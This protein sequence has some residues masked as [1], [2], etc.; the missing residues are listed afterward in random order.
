MSTKVSKRYVVNRVIAAGLR[1][2][3]AK[4]EQG[5]EELAAREALAKSGSYD[6]AV[7]KSAGCSG[8][9]HKC[10][11]KDDEGLEMAEE[12]VK[13]DDEGMEMA[14]GA[15]TKVGGQ[16]PVRTSV[17]AND[18]KPGTVLQETRPRLPRRSLATVSLNAAPTR[19]WEKSE[20]LDKGAMDMVL[21]R[22]PFKPAGTLA[23]P[24]SPGMTP[25]AASLKSIHAKL[26]SPPPPPAAAMAV[27]KADESPGVKAAIKEGKLK[28]HVPCPHCKGKDSTEHRDG[29]RTCLSCYSEFTPHLKVAK[30]DDL[31]EKTKTLFEKE[32]KKKD[33]LPKGPSPSG[34]RPG[35][36]GAC[37]ECGVVGH[38]PSEHV[39][40]A[41]GV[42]AA[43]RAPGAKMGKDEEDMAK[44]VPSP[45]TRSGRASPLPSPRCTSTTSR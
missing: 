35:S 43:P 29:S 5:V 36:G 21:G 3:L 44:K 18:W 45:P 9:M 6:P 34:A 37:S 26:K 4:Y 13:K 1:T 7:C 2:Y 40:K 24:A 14:E 25:P 22:Q 33:V 41:D 17:A 42:P 11:A 15:P 31:S 16:A 38:S 23:P 28:T 10:M 8:S 12:P 20:D 27:R 32:P 39:K 30:A 19:A